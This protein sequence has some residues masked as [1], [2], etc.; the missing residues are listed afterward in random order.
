MWLFPL[1]EAYPN[2]TEGSLSWDSWNDS[3]FSRRRPSFF[4]KLTWTFSPGSR[5]VPWSNGEPA[6]EQAFSVLS[7]VDR[8]HMARPAPP[9]EGST[10]AC[11]YKEGHHGSHLANGLHKGESVK[12]F[13]HRSDM[14][15]PLLK[16]SWWMLHARLQAM[17]M[18]WEVQGSQLGDCCD[19]ADERWWKMGWNVTMRSETRS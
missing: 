16:G 18:G 14:I 2:G 8:S 19:N 13:V 6:H 15:W 7:Q 1:P 5:S 10:R 3:G 11:G 4:R 17:G 9:W 12:D